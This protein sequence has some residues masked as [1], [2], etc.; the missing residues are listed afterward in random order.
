VSKIRFLQFLEVLL[1]IGG[2][3]HPWA[4]RNRRG[5]AERI[6]FAEVPQL[7]EELQEIEENGFCYWAQPL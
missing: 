1:L 5:S 7:K 2:L 3:A 4:R 6:R